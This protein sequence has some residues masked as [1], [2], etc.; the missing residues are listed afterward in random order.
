MT[1]L[2]KL[3]SA[4]RE[5]DVMTASAQRIRGTVYA[6]LP[7]MSAGALVYLTGHP[8]TF[9][10]A[11]LGLFSALAWNFLRGLLAMYRVRTAVFGKCDCPKCRGTD[12][13][14]LVPAS[15]NDGTEWL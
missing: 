10:T 6:C 7:V 11:C 8:V 13:R 15:R 4:Y 1:S 14:A 9:G 2:E 3:A 12:S 5:L